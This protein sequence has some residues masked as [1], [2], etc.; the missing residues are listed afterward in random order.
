MLAE[1]VTISCQ[2]LVRMCRVMELG[3]PHI[4]LRGSA[5]WLDDDTDRAADEAMR[6]DFQ[7][8]GLIN[9][10]GRLDGDALDTI[11]CLVQ[12]RAE[13]IAAITQGDKVRYI[14]A[15]AGSWETVVAVRDGDT[16]ELR[17]VH[18]TSPPHTLIRELPEAPAA[19]IG[20]LTIPLGRPELS[21]RARQDAAKLAALSKQRCGAR[22][23]LFVGIHDSGG[24]RSNQ[25]IPIVYADYESGRALLTIANGKVHVTG[26]T[27]AMLVDRLTETYRQLKTQPW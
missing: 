16:I 24:Y 20:S 4:L 1:P 13:Y 14:V 10:S 5:V 7:R 22:G 19:R 8:Y 23:E 6:D 18:D 9:R 26:A 11:G 2:S 17:S 12:P 27:K 3:T 15:A 21:Y 25:D